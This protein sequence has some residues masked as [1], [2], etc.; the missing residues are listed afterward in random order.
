[1]FSCLVLMRTV[2]VVV[3]SV[4]KLYSLIMTPV[5][6]I[7]FCQ[8]ELVTHQYEHINQ[9]WTLPRF[10][11]SAPPALKRL[12]ISDQY[13]FNHELVVTFYSWIEQED[14]GRIKITNALGA[15]ANWLAL[16]SKSANPSHMFSYLLWALRHWSCLDFL[17]TVV[18][19]LAHYANKC[20]TLTRKDTKQL[21]RLIF[22]SEVVGDENGE[23]WVLDFTLSQIPDNEAIWVMRW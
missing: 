13:F 23:T 4:V 5:S 11:G 9:S 2:Q 8:G 20:C 3:R 6:I 17:F 15:K 10:R 21:K 18:F 14:D 22:P 1:M 16:A 7:L 12:I 19:N